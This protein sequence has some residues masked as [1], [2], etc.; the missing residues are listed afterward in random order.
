M[1]GTDIYEFTIK[2]GP[3]HFAI[4]LKNCVNVLG[5]IN[6]TPPPT[7]FRVNKKSY[8]QFYLLNHKNMPYLKPSINT[9]FEKF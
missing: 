3:R 9:V 6:L 8:P 1:T 7:L 2:F 4:F 5:C